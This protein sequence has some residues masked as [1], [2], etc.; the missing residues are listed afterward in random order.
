MAENCC[1]KL[2]VE[3]C[4]AKN[5]M[6]KDGQGTASAYVLV[7]FD[8]QRRRTKTKF[9]DL[10]PQWDE[11]L[12]FLVHDPDTM[13]SETL[14]LNVYNDKKT[15]KRSTFLGKVKL[16]GSSFSQAGSETLIYY[17]LDKRSVFSQIKGEIGLK[18]YF[19]NENPP[20][21]E[22]AAAADPKSEAPASDDAG[23]AG[24][25]EEKKAP[26]NIEEKPEEKKEEEKPAAETPAKE[27]K[28]APED[29][30]PD[31]AVTP[32]KEVEKPPIAADGGESKDQKRNLELAKVQSDCGVNP[33]DI[34]SQRLLGGGDL[35]VGAYDL[36]ERMLYLYVRVVKSKPT[37]TSSPV[38][39]KL[40]IGT[41]SIRTRTVQ[42]TEWDQVFAFH[43]EDL[44]SASLE[45]SVWAEKK[46][47][48]TDTTTE[49]S[50]GAVSFDLQEVPK[51][52]P[53]DSPL[54]PQWYTLEGAPESSPG[55]DVM[56][57]VWIG[58]QADE[59]FQEAWQSDSGGLIAETRAKAYLSPKLWYLR[60][61]V[62]QTQDL[63]LGSGAE[64][65]A[66][67]TEL[68]VRAQ[69]G[70]QV[71]KTS[72]STISSLTGTT[73]PTWNE[74]LVFVAAEPFEP[75]LVIGVE[76]VT[77]GQSVGQAKV[78]VPSVDRRSDDRTEPRSRWFNLVGDESRPYTGRIHLRICLEGGYHVLD[79]AAHM[80]SDV[81]AASKHLAKPP[82]GSLEIGIRGASNLLPMKTKDGTRG[83]TDA[84]VVAKYG[85]KWFRTRTLID[86]FNPRWNEQYAWDVYDPCTVLT[87]GVFDNGRYKGDESAGKPGKDRDVRIG[88]VRI[89]LSTLDTNHVYMNSYSLTLLHPSGAKKMGEIE[90][91]VRFTCPSWISLIQA[92]ASPMLPRMHYVKPLGPA[93]QD[94][95]RQTA[96]RI[97]TG[98][99]GRSEPPLGQEVV[100]YMLDSDTHVWS[101]RRSRANWFRVV[102]CL[103][104][105][106]ALA[107]WL[108]GVCSWVHPST[109][110][111]V[112]LL[113]A[114]VVL[115]PHLI[116]PTAFMYLF[117]ILVWRYRYR[118]MAPTNI[119]P[120]LSY[121]DVVGPDEID[122]EFDGFP[123]SRGPDQIRIR[124]DRLRAL[125]GR[126]QT[127]LGD[128][129]AQ[130][131]R[132]E[133]LLNWRDPRA[134]GIFVVFCLFAS[135]V[136]YA[137]PFK[138]IVL[139]LG[140]YYLRHPRFRDDMPTVPINIF[141]RLPS[142]ADRI[143]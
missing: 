112:H 98:R 91:A 41:N 132:V 96:M 106:V 49:S 46:D 116:L 94:V 72:K 19:V 125:A 66:R 52:V 8:G 60:L 74:D 107:R 20:T 26:E 103:S 55:N 44:N 120:R 57:A 114:A 67:T 53:P 58:T 105:A 25:E 27:G 83:T 101:M 80:T 24:K 140:F 115:C 36:V 68:Y 123:S 9:R 130:G 81:R 45:V 124:Y 87:V 31:A 10:N 134:T 48:D 79:E 127:L 84:Y 22:S 76:D 110:I 97:V 69:L 29:P 100:Q 109:T 117:F 38:Y 51:R 70:P 35:A 39:A 50:I 64:P 43:K 86:R 95:L 4:N 3:V 82:I 62:I 6:P 14:E 121:V 71:F 18:V 135:L 54:A 122:E 108:D 136:L 126:A 133:A 1:R 15:G 28:K 143:L 85:P 78:H 34:R 59:A 47:T 40:V 89:R 37:D 137:V 17:P 16:S 23:A 104:W 93:Q 111:L 128:M 2:F 33:V 5:L 77:S 118:H 7:D 138:A 102:G 141:L 119:D 99:L 42:N 88:K 65:K 56:L 92:Y 32:A 139:F 13:A 129:A 131:E 75:F 73:N 11:K 61:T 63:Q 90:L 21:S 12:E 30:K 142:H 113:L